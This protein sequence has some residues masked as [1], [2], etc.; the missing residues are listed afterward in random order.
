MLLE[1]KI[2]YYQPP[3]ELVDYAAEHTPSDQEYD[4]WEVEYLELCRELGVEN[5]LVHK[6]WP[7][8]EDVPGDG[9]ME[10]DWSRPSADCALQAIYRKA[11]IPEGARRSLYRGETRAKTQ[12]KMERKRKKKKRSGKSKKVSSGP[13]TSTEEVQD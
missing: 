6:S 8:F 2:L 7:G 11:G 13:E 10:V 4:R 9:M 3:I 12:K 5:T 1:A